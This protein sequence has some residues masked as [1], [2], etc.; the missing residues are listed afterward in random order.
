MSKPN[1]PE[2]FIE[3]LELIF[4]KTDSQKI[5]NTFVSRPTTFRVN[6]LKSNKNEVL[7]KLQ[8]NAFKI[9]R[10]SWFGDAFI[11]ENKS[12]SEFMKTDLFLSGKIYL[13]SLASMV[14]VLF[15]EPKAGDK[16]LDLTAAPGSK[17]SQIASLMNKTGELVASE[18]DKIRFEKLTH[19]M[20]LLGVIDEEKTDWNFKLLNEDGVKIFEN[21]KNYFDKILLDAPCGAEARIDLSD[22]RSY[23]FW[24]EKNIKNNAFLQKKLLFS[25]WNSLKVGGELVYSTCTFAP[26]ENEEQILWLKEKFPEAVE[27]EKIDLLGLVKSKSLLNWKEK[28]FPEDIKK[29][30]RILPDKYI[31]GFFVVKIKKIK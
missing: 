3:R 11:L 27:I 1:L 25:A 8:Q 31:E 28:K 30:L 10:V 5:L 21:Y 2:K 15:L 19:N 23:S 13:Q 22:R 14:P 24:N 20:N 9:K 4:G 16:V 7:E 6:T 29:C 17:T 26:E 12:Q 18:I